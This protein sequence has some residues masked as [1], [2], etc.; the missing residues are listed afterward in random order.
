M[1]HNQRR[2]A[3]GIGVE[4]VAGTPVTPTHWLQVSDAPALNDKVENENIE[5]ARGRIEMS[6]GQKPMKKY[7]EGNIALLLDAENAT[8]PFGLILG[9]TVSAS[10]GGGLYEHT[11]TIDVTNTPKTATIVIDRVQDVRK[12]ANAVLQEINISVADSFAKITMTFQSKLSATA[13]AVDSYEEVICMTFKELSAQFGTTVSNAGSAE[14]TPLSGMDLNIIR[15]VEK[16]FQSGDNEPNNFVYKTL[17]VNGNYSLL[18]DEVAN[19]DKY[20]NNTQNAG[21]F[22]FTDSD[23]GFIKITIPNLRIANWEPD[24]DLNEIVS[25]TADF[26]GHYDVTQDEGIRVVTKNSTASFTNL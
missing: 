8:I 10:A 23:G 21:I 2:G 18:F 16:I 13:T 12:F 9:S 19:R 4:A 3:V 15:E 6:Q 25:Q 26:Q 14:A 7:S 17:Q 22:T 20:L 24:N 1:A 11:S 5:S